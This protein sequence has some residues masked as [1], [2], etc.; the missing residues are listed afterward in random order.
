MIALTP[1]ALSTEP[2]HIMWLTALLAP[3][4]APNRIFG[5]II[6]DVWI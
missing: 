4:I 2:D 6:M 5:V 1:T 3:G